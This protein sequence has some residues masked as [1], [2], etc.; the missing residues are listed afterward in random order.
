M[1]AVGEGVEIS[2]FPLKRNIAYTTGCCY[3]TSRDSM[4][5]HIAFVG[6]PRVLSLGCHGLVV[7]VTGK[8]A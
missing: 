4:L 2:L 6:F 8:S 7:D 1:G 5:L 3:G